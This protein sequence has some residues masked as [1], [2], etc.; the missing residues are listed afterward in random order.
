MAA[1]EKR[2]W[3]KAILAGVPQKK[4]ARGVANGLCSLTVAR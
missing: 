3:R 2:N 1:G 4:A